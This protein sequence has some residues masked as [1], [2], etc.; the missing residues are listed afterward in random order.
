MKKNVSFS[1]VCVLYVWI[2]RAEMTDTHYDI[3]RPVTSVDKILDRIFHTRH[4]VNTTNFGMTLEENCRLVEAMPHEEYVK[5]YELGRKRP[6]TR[7]QF[8]IVK[9]IYV[10]RTRYIASMRM[11]DMG[12]RDESLGEIE[13]SDDAELR[14]FI[15]MHQGKIIPMVNLHWMYQV[16]CVM[17]QRGRAKWFSWNLD[18]FKRNVERLGLC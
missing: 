4:V 18:D 10:L 5:R 6:T 1:L 16:W 2:L 3:P 9:G 15:S 12:I 17:T 14:Q 8:E 7:D 13:Q 11:D